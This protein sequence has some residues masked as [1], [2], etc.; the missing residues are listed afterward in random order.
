MSNAEFLDDDD[1]VSLLPEVERSEDEGAL[2]VWRVLVVDDDED[3]H[4]TTEFALKGVMILGRPVV[5]LHARSAGEA[6][7]RATESEEIAIALVDVVMETP[8]AGLRLVGELREAGFREMRIVL[9]TGQPGYAPELSVI[10]SYE[11]D[12]YRTKDELTRTRLLTVLTSSI[13]AYDQLRT[14]TRSRMGL[15]MIVK[16]A[17]KLFQRTNL[18]LFSRGVLTQITALLRI[19]PNGIVCVNA[20]A[21]EPVN[22]SRIVSAMGRFAHLIGKT[23]DAV[24]D[25]RIHWLLNKARERSE[26]ALRNGYTALHFHSK[27]GRELWVV[28]ETDG[29]LAPEDL[30]LVKVFSTNI[31]VGFENLALVEKLDRLAYVDPV[32]EVPNL[33][34]FEDALL[35]RLVAGTPNWRMALVSVDSFQTTAAAYGSRVANDLLSEV[36]EKLAGN[37]PGERTVAR[38]GDSS[39][40]LLGPR[41]ALDE[42]FLQAVFALPYNL[43]GVEITTA[44]TAAIV[45]LD[46]LAGDPATA[47]QA[48]NAALW[49]VQKAQP[50]KFTQYD[51][52]L[53]AAVER[54]LQLQKDLRAAVESGEGLSVAM[55]PKFN[56][57]TREVVGAEALA[58]WMLDGEAIPP[59]EFIPVA[60]SA[61]V[62]HR[63]TEFMVQSVGAW[64]KT[65][66]GQPPL[67]VAV[68]LSMIDLNNPGFAERL[69]RAIAAAGLSPETIA[70]EV[71]E[72]VAMQ[73]TPWAIEQL[74]TL[75]AEGFQIALDDFGTGYS[76]LSHFSKLP[77]NVLKID[78]S[79]VSALDPETADNSLAAVVIAMTR[80]L[81]VDCVAEGIETE[82][83]R[84]MLTTLGCTLG[85]GYLLGRPVPIGDFAEKFLKGS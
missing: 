29:P 43:N 76:S 16:S 11:I 28:I 77:V 27:P 12:D 67:Q 20:A 85:Q 6:L 64:T 59:V 22:N 49:H 68:N 36:Y 23:M 21:Q 3:V 13:R 62:M 2:H 65:R 30:A 60:E 18:E 72:G 81:N 45:E 40:A 1:V 56:L 35:T 26:P 7:E 75:R 70:F 9:R 63:L 15:E 24:V 61:G 47:M 69:L 83:Q 8:D 10:S 46:E 4:S 79:F 57:V 50:G 39:F 32:L 44:A 58:R 38:M 25:S 5:L 71:T 14:I 82:E 51:A 34:A 19:A 17:T 74:R 42:S 41:E 48:A 52:A 73:E 53:R 84:E 55:Q 54:R 31:A 80:A 33:N 78:R 66:E 37:G